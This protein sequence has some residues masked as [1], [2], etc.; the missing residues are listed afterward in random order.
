MHALTSDRALHGLP[1]IQQLLNVSVKKK[2]E[3]ALPTSSA[4]VF[5]LLE[6]AFIIGG[7]GVLKNSLVAIGKSD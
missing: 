7:L 5:F 1:P 3:N 4:N 2:K 6:K